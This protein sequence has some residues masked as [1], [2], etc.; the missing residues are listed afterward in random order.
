[1]DVIEFVGEIAS[2]PADEIEI[3][4]LPDRAGAIPDLG[5]CETRLGF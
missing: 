1:M 4:A 2:S 3:A 5:Q